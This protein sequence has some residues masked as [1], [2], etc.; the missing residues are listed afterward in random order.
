MRFGARFAGSG[1]FGRET[2]NESFLLLLTFMI[3]VTVP[4][5]ALSADVAMRRRTEDALRAVHDDLNRR[6]AA[7]TAALTGANLA[8]QEEI[9][10]RKRVETVLDQQTRHLVEAQRLAN[11]GSWVRNLETNEIVWS[12]QLY[13]IFGVQ[14]GEE[15]AGTFDGLSQA[16]PSRRS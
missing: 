16:R 8:L 6:V 11:L 13:E 7:R 10:R 5:L 1:P 2:L 3:G 15:N 9:D 4:S 12:E 14:P